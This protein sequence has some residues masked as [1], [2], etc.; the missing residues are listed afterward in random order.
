MKIG[1]I[2]PTTL[3]NEDILVLPRGENVIVFRARGLPNMDEFNALV[4]EPKA[5]SKMTA[6]GMV[7]DVENRD[8]KQIVEEYNKRRMA[9]LMVKSLEPSNIEWDLVKPDV[10]GTWALWED[11]LK[12][13]GKGL[14]QI[15]V[16]LVARLAYDANSLDEAK[17][18]KA[19]ETFLHGPTVASAL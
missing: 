17:L 11:D 1:G 6:S 5:P 16:N 18:R 4:P 12:C 7:P 3:P 13:N 10:P 15:E 19:R 8:Y 14:T 9:Y 2:D